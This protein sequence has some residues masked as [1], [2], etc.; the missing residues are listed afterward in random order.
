MRSTFWPRLHENLFFFNGD[1]WA[2]WWL[3][4]DSTEPLTQ[5]S[6]LK[7]IQI[8]NKFWRK[9]LNANKFTLV[10][11]LKHP[12]LWIRGAM[13][14]IIWKVLS[15]IIPTGSSNCSQESDFCLIKKRRKSLICHL[16]F[17][18]SAMCYWCEETNN[19]STSV[20]VLTFNEFPFWNICIKHL[21]FLATVT[22]K[23]TLLYNN[24]YRKK[25][26]V[27]QSKRS[28]CKQ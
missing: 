8:S 24:I 14:N 6:F 23:F 1:Q 26:H 12:F 18:I 16:S 5:M 27:Y 9:T 25:K 2:N 21:C 13:Y 10:L 22:F 17:E 7:V 11:I 19:T 28:Y 20:K 3:Q 15:T 4:N